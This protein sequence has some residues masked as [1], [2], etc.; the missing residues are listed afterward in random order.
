MSL[1]V[2]YRKNTSTKASLITK[3]INCMVSRYACYNT[4][5]NYYQE[6]FALE[7]CMDVGEINVPRE[8]HGT[9]DQSLPL[10]RGT[11]SSGSEHWSNLTGLGVKRTPGPHSIAAVMLQ[12]TATGLV[13]VPLST[14]W[15]SVTGRIP[16][17]RDY[18]YGYPY[19]KHS[20]R[21]QTHNCW[22]RT[23]AKV[24]GPGQNWESHTG[25]VQNTTIVCT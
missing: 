11:A 7:F 14:S 1:F 24:V 19:R 9:R 3:Q 16:E 8:S 12:V 23:G 20:T 10:S 21:Q 2:V 17:D 25:P 6:T 18:R 5:A 4:G 22:S 13:S 15:R